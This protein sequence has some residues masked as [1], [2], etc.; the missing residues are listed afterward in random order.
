MIRLAPS[1]LH[2]QLRVALLV[3]PSDVRN[4]FAAGPA[5]RHGAIDRLASLLADGLSCLELYREEPSRAAALELPLF[6]SIQ[7][8]GDPP[9]GPASTPTVAASG[10]GVFARWLIEQR[11]RPGWIGDLGRAAHADRS[12]PSGGDVGDVRG[13]LDRQRASGDDYEALEAAELDW[14][15]L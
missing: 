10:S 8:V 5:E 3:A 9:V 15:A 14:L 12:F 11:K 6:A 2:E 4:A 7:T 1:D 13:W